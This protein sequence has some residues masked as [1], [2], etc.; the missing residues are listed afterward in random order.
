[1]LVCLPP[2]P[3][4]QPVHVNGSSGYGSLGSNDH[5]MSVASSSESTGNSG[6]RAARPEEDERGKAKPVSQLPFCLSVCLSLTPDKIPTS[7]LCFLSLNSGIQHMVCPLEII[8]FPGFTEKVASFVG[9]Y[10]ILCSPLATHKFHLSV[11]AI[12]GLLSQILLLVENP[13]FSCPQ[14]QARRSSLKDDTFW[15]QVK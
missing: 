14:V 3:P 9:I 15:S 13:E 12:T 2:P 1:M 11:R 7:Q 10:N 4:P 6:P 5:L 8:Y